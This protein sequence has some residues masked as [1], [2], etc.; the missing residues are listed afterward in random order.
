MI[1]LALEGRFVAVHASSLSY[2]FVF[3]FLKLCHRFI[4]K[5]LKR[6]TDPC[7]KKS[8][9]YVYNI[10]GKEQWFNFSL[11]QFI[12]AKSRFGPP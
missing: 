6:T 1:N 4:P 3:L 9:I 12:R 2:V 7:Q 8:D 10:P 5:L 11:F